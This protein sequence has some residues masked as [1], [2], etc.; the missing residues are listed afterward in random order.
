MLCTVCSV[1][2]LIGSFYLCD[3][4]LSALPLV[5]TSIYSLFIKYLNLFKHTASQANNCMYPRQ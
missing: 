2:I 1:A 5:L 4:H 3:H